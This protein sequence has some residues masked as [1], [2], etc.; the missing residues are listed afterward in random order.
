MFSTVI[1]QVTLLIGILIV[2]VRRRK[3]AVAD[4]ILLALIVWGMVWGLVGAL[5]A[6]PLTAIVRILLDK[7]DIT[8]P[9]AELM[10]GRLPSTATPTPTK[11]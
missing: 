7:E 11:P 10:A 1:D 3:Y 8:R 4:S 5:L 2:L 6:T 9:A